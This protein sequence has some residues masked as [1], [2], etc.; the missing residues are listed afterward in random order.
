MSAVLQLR[1]TYE[2]YLAREE[3]AD[4]RSEFYRGE[5]F[6]MSGGTPR[7]NVIGVNITVSSRGRLRGTGCRPYSSDQRIRVTKNGL[8]T[9]PDVSV[10]CGDLQLH[11]ED[12]NAV[13]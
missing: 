1:Y 9:Y 11:A 13:T 7:H 6:A 3:A 5:I 4:Y 2:Q 8:A 10:V 12:P